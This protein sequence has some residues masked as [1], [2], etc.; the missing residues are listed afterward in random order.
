M[1]R[2][3]PGELDKK[4]K[5]PSIKEDGKVFDCE[6]T[7]EEGV[8][9]TEGEL[10]DISGEGADTTEESAGEL[11]EVKGVIDPEVSEQSDW[12]S[13]L[14]ESE[15]GEEEEGE[16]SPLRLDSDEDSSGDNAERGEAKSFR[17]YIKC[18]GDMGQSANGSTSDD[19]SFAA[20]NYRNPHNHMKGKGAPKFKCEYCGRMFRRR[21]YLRAHYILHEQVPHQCELCGKVFM[22][23]RYLKRHYRAKHH[24]C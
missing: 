24:I 18:S 5:L 7:E 2:A 4:G 10:A 20:M 19:S 17:Q 16:M 11:S 14:G 12:M 3:F 6:S 8:L 9:D 1:R 21:A 22:T 15:D 23:Q 13:G